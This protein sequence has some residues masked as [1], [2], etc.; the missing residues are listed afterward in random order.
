MD[1]GI[2]YIATGLPYINEAIIAAASC[3][4]HNNYPIA[5]V[6]DAESYDLPAGLFDIVIIKP[7]RFSYRDK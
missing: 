7:A 5:L 3:K 2:L 4:K 1:K 6:T